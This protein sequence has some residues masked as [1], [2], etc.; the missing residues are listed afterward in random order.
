MTSAAV[1]R[2][3]ALRSLAGA[4]A[5]AASLASAPN[6]G[7]AASAP[8][9]EPDVT[10]RPEWSGPLPSEVVAV[11][12][13][14]KFPGEGSLAALRAK[15]EAHGTSILTQ[16]AASGVIQ[17]LSAPFVAEQ[18]RRS[19]SMGA[20]VAA[21]R[22]L[23]DAGNTS[24]MLAFCWKVTWDCRGSPLGSLSALTDVVRTIQ[25][26]KALDPDAT[27]EGLLTVAGKFAIPEDPVDVIVLSGAG[28]G[29]LRL[30]DAFA[31]QLF[32]EGE[33]I[34]MAQRFDFEC[35]LLDVL[36]FESARSQRPLASRLASKLKVF[37]ELGGLAYC[38]HA[39]HCD[40]KSKEARAQ[41]LH[42]AMHQEAPGGPLSTYFRRAMLPRL[43][44]LS[45]RLVGR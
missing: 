27:V 7:A 25:Q 30:V 41:I 20:I 37:G 9:L 1:S 26:T 43:Q 17:N 13:S 28:D 4:S 10:M 22:L 45:D 11:V 3:S 16:L 32:S 38:V 21:L 24:Q 12:Q 8:K 2:R 35:L 19:N 42:R 14:E 15:V 34:A 40:E 39:L 18:L 23:S 6:C 29:N 44:A 36:A 33:P 5:Y 31:A